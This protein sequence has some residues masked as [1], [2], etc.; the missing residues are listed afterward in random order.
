MT[1][2]YTFHVQGMHCKACVALIETELKELPQV[3]SAQA[4]L[5]DFMTQVMGEFN[6]EGAA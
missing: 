4:S 5:K 1:K 6:E 2:T 3:T